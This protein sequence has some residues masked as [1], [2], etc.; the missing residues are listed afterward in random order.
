MQM[1]ADILQL[2]VEVVEGTEQGTLGASICAG[3]ATK[4]FESFSEAAQS[5]V[6]ISKTYTPNEQHQAIYEQK[7]QAYLEVLEALQPLWKKLS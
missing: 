3:V 4:H 1:F 2:P 7:Y 6:K 5:M